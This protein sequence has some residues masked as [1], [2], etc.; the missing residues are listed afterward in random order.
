MAPPRASS[1]RRKASVRSS[2]AKMLRVFF[3]PPQLGA[4]STWS[5]KQI[6]S[7][8]AARAARAMPSMGTMAS[9]DMLEWVW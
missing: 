6:S 1:A 4:K 5:V 7:I 8:P 3:H 2:Q 9:G